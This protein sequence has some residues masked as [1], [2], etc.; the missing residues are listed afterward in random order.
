[1]F[2]VALY[3]IFALPLF[4][5]DCDYTLTCPTYN[6]I[7]CTNL[8][9]HEW[10]VESD[11]EQIETGTQNAHSFMHPCDYYYTDLYC[12][13]RLKSRIFEFPIRL[14]GPDMRFIVCSVPADAPP[15]RILKA[16]SAIFLCLGCIVSP[17]AGR[18]WPP[19]NGER[20]IC[21]SNLNIQI[22]LQFSCK[23]L[24]AASKEIRL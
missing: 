22:N 23:C 9:I 18:P 2:A 7:P 1:M 24:F 4:I 21:S 3:I 12:R 11:N 5:C 8:F 10:F 16:L 14:C 19:T 15:A 17:D 20:T 13:T 6:T